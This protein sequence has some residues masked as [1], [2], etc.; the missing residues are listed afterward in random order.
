M[1]TW[2]SLLLVYNHASGNSPFCTRITRLLPF[3]IKYIVTINGMSQP[4]ENIF[5]ASTGNL[6]I[7]GGKIIGYRNLK[8]L[9]VSRSCTLWSEKIL[10]CFHQAPN[11][12][13]LFQ[14]VCCLWYF[15]RNSWNCR[16]LKQSPRHLLLRSRVPFDESIYLQTVSQFSG[17]ISKVE[18]GQCSNL[19]LNR[20]AR[21]HNS[22]RDLLWLFH[23]W[24]IM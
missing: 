18:G 10:C 17:P 12:S 23:Y 14:I 8:M 24:A 13:L 9:L 6:P 7:L 15:W 19:S 22:F 4:L 1:I 5:S 16:S 21:I 11:T 3:I 20:S 2:R